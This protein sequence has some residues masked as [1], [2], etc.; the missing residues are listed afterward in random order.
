MKPKNL[1]I[2]DI[3]IGD[4]A[5]FDRIFTESNVKLFS[6]LSGDMN[7]LHI[8]KRYAKTTKFK[9][10]IVHGMLVGSLCSTLVGMY[11]PG[12]KCLY[13]GQILWFKK[14]I[15]IGET[16]TVR[17]IVVSKSVSTGIIKISISIMRGADEV[18][19][20]EAVVQVLK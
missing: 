14:P 19:S 8:D 4:S 6:K 3:N 10:R 20:G 7:P 16:V 9:H 1:S 12:K 17:G 11:L 15:F 18:T 13:L 2:D 5:S